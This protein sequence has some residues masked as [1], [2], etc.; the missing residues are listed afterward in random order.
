M[1]KSYSE[2]VRDILR[3]QV[4]AL[5]TGDDA[6][7]RKRVYEMNTLAI[8]MALRIDSALEEFANLS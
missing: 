7:Y 5:S 8:D 3:A 6:S 4:Y 1:S 2:S